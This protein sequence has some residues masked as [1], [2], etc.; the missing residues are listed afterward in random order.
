MPT[1]IETNDTGRWGLDI[2]SISSSTNVRRL[3]VVEQAKQVAVDQRLTAAQD[4][5]IDVGQAN[6]NVPTSRTFSAAAYAQAAQYQIYSQ[7][8]MLTSLVSPHGLSP[9]AHADKAATIKVKAVDSSTKGARLD[10]LA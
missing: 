6:A 2:G 9:P 7:S 3:N 8:G 10:T 5:Q 1:E 4:Q